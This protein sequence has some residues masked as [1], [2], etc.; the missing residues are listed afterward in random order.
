MENVREE[1]RNS[2]EDVEL[3][4]SDDGEDNIE[5]FE[6]ESENSDDGD[7]DDLEAKIDVDD[8][9]EVFSASRIA[10]RGEG[11][12]SKSSA[13]PDADEEPS[14][15]ESS[16][17]SRRSRA[18]S[19][20]DSLVAHAASLSLN[21]TLDK[22]GDIDDGR[23]GEEADAAGGGGLSGDLNLS[24]GYADASGHAPPPASIQERVAS[25]VVRQRA[26][27]AGKYHAK[28]GARKAGR[29]KGSKAK[30]DTRVRMD[31]SGVWE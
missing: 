27:Q 5:E 18:P 16:C 25:E 30:Q 28:R 13:D 22:A 20:T 10:V 4:G 19:P 9:A 8:G 1:T 7:E 12:A 2:D 15:A 23:V 11:A 14:G 17:S 24:M 6:Y 29:P 21:D 3:D 26:R 31:R